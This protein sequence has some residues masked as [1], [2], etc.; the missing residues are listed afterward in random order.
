ML[1]QCQSF[2]IATGGNEA[3]EE[4]GRWWERGHVPGG[5]TH[6]QW[7]TPPLLPSGSDFLRHTGPLSGFCAGLRSLPAGPCKSTTTSESSVAGLGACRAWR[8]TGVDAAAW[9]CRLQV[10]RVLRVERMYTYQ[11][12]YKANVYQT[13]S[14]HCLV[15]EWNICSILYSRN[16]LLQPV[17]RGLLHYRPDKLFR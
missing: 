11:W 3:T 7:V 9:C 12:Y 4:R 13:T 2:K 17:R 16:R 1:C 10:L 14:T 15:S 8:A 5:I 6:R